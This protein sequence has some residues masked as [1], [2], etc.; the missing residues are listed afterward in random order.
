MSVIIKIPG[1]NNSNQEQC[2]RR[3]EDDIVRDDSSQY[4]IRRQRRAEERFI[5]K[6][7]VILSPSSI[8]YEE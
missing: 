1:D 5:L 8:Q 3:I 4:C 7:T 2:F 6:P